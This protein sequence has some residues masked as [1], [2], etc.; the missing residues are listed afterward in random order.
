MTP[1]RLA[2]FAALLLVLAL[3][4]SASAAVI[5]PGGDDVSDAIGFGTLKPSP[6]VRGFDANT[7][8]YTTEPNEFDLCPPSVYG[9]T[10]WGRFKTPRTGRIDITAAGF[11]SVIALSPRN[12]FGEPGSGPCVARLSGRIESFGR[13]DLPTVKKGRS[14]FIQVG[15]FAYFDGRPAQPARG[16]A[17]TVDVELLPPSVLEG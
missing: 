4:S 8:T 1:K 3:A 7:S 5:P 10:I 17:L 16:G 2:I 6:S 15:G 14:Y 9:K 13:D 11:D 12:R